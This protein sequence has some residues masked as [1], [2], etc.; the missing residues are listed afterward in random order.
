MPSRCS[1]RPLMSTPPSLFHDEAETQLRE[2]LR[3]YFGRNA[4]EEML[5]E[6]LSRLAEH[7]GMYL[8][9]AQYEDVEF[10]GFNLRV[11]ARR[12]TCTECGWENEPHAE[13]DYL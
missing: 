5:T 2:L 9:E 8:C 11:V 13:D 6:F 3:D 7:H 12:T 1:P 4:L 10:E